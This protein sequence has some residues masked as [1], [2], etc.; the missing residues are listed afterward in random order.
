[1]ENI[2]NWKESKAIRHIYRSNKNQPFLQ[3]QTRQGR[4]ESSDAWP[5]DKSIY[6]NKYDIY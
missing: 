2:Y 3:Y 6:N 4:R 1:M 5:K